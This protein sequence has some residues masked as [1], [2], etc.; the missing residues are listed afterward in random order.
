MADLTGS[1]HYLS[2]ICT[3]GTVM[4]QPAGYIRGLGEGLRRDGIGVFENS[5]VT[6][7]VR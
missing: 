6:G 5:P 3:P 1:R 7:I 2:G 4:L